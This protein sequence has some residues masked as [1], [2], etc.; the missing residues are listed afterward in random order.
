M[1][2]EMRNDAA[3]LDEHYKPNTPSSPSRPATPDWKALEE[4][5]AAAARWSEAARAAAA[6]ASQATVDAVLEFA[7][8]ATSLGAESRLEIASI[9]DGL[10]AEV[11]AAQQQLQILAAVAAGVLPTDDSKVVSTDWRT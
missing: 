8:H 6:A 4:A 7:H 1:K 3:R 9:A 11:K 2:E 5:D 10:A